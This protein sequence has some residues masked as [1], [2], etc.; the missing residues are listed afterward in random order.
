MT[1]IKIHTVRWDADAIQAALHMNRENME[2]VFK[3]G[4]M[5]YHFC[6]PKVAGLFPDHDPYVIRV[7]TKGGV[8]FSPSSMR[9]K[10]RRFD[11]L[12]FTGYLDSIDFFA[13][14]DPL[15]FPTATV[16]QVPSAWVRRWWIS[17]RVHHEAHVSRP[18]FYSLMEAFSTWHDSTA[19]STAVA[20]P[21]PAPDTNPTASEVTSAA[22]M[23]ASKSADAST[24]TET[25]SSPWP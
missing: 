12:G 22:G 7:L 2:A 18:H 19:P 24:P 13:V 5:A 11:R 20:A 23:L 10:G 15:V 9:G 25:T 8:N 16:F 17:G 3:D 1:P 6:K 21:P 4:R 14:V